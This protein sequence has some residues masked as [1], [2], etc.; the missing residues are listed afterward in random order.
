MK[1]LY[2]FLFALACLPSLAQTKIKTLSLND[3]VSYPAI[4]RPGDFYVVTKTSQIQRFDKDGKLTLLYKAP[5]FPTLFDPRDG[6]RLFV[7]YREKQ[8]Y[9]FMSPS[10][11]PTTS[12]RIDSAFAIQPWLIC[13]SGDHNLWVLDSMDHTLKKINIKASEV[14]VEVAVDSSLIRNATAFKTMRDYQGFVFLLN[15]AKGIFIF[16]AL[17]KH[18]RTLDIPGIEHFNFLGEELYYLKGD[19]L[20][21]F[22]L[23][24]TETRELKV[25][26]GYTTALLTDERMI[27]FAPQKVDIYEFRP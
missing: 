19:T 23:F 25:D 14:E 11:E 26:A 7:Y 17:G 18:I 1:L 24:T 12:Y 16:N 13:P 22:N 5:L 8:R 2:T 20:N 27:L 15:P 10:F 6:A 9:E 3:T 4:D 21:F